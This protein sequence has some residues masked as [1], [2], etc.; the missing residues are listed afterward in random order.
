MEA[1]EPAQLG[2]VELQARLLAL[3]V[4]WRTL[5]EK[6]EADKST[7]QGTSTHVWQYDREGTELF[8]SVLRRVK[9]AFKDAP[10]NAL[11]FVMGGVVGNIFVPNLRSVANANAPLF[12]FSSR[13]NPSPGISR[14][15]WKTKIDLRPSF[16]STS[17]SLPLLE[18]LVSLL[19][20]MA[21]KSP[22]EWLSAWCTEVHN[23]CRALRNI[24]RLIDT[25][26]FTWG[27]P[28]SFNMTEDP[29]RGLSVEKLS[30][31]T[32]EISSAVESYTWIVQHMCFQMWEPMT[33]LH[34]SEISWLFFQHQNSINIDETVAFSSFFECDTCSIALRCS[35]RS[36][37]SCYCQ[38]PPKNS[39]CGF[40]GRKACLQKLQP[41]SKES[42]HVE[43][44]KNSGHCALAQI[45]SVSLIDRESTSAIISTK[46]IYPTS[47][48][49]ML[50][51]N[52]NA[53]HERNSHG[54]EQQVPI[55][56][57]SHPIE[58][59]NDEMDMSED[60]T[61]VEE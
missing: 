61:S 14:E 20:E 25:K 12:A 55:G 35:V 24:L 54:I 31:L 26:T 45:A 47:V 33:R 7:K 58:W 29:W 13:G 56:S 40:W 16:V 6:L 5:K 39:P 38:S 23:I 28:P 11:K 8:Q 27:W 1:Q 22:E 32:V 21:V 41:V 10:E 57:T 53:S 42:Y 44:M 48:L 19:Q 36:P 59:E 49:E 60:G 51:N 37:F 18:F 17:L 4:G 34:D 46:G 3:L 9:P 15:L 30:A 2:K 50:N 43:D 52:N